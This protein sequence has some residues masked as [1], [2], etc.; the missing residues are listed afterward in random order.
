LEERGKIYW[1]GAFFE[2]LQMEFQQYRNYLKFQSEHQLSKEA[3]RMDV[4]IIKKNKGVRIEKNIG[5]IFREHNVFDYKSESDS[6]S[7][8][9]YN[10]VF[11]YVGLYSSF[12]RVP[13]SEITVSIALTMFPRK[14]VKS[15]E[16][17]RGL[18][19]LDL[20]DGIYR[21]DGE[22]IP[23]QILE[24]KRL[25]P[26]NNMF[27]RNLR[28]N[29]STEDASRTLELG[30]K[31]NLL[32]DKSV[33]MDRLIKANLD[34]FME[35]MNMVSETVKELFLEGAEKH[36]WLNKRDEQIKIQDR[37]ETAKKLLLLGDSVEKV[38][39]VTELPIE[40]VRDLLL[41]AQKETT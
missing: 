26:D 34:A 11:G 9:D 31:Y 23:V 37:K 40:T 19:V 7:L 15:L 16:D 8:W 36:G 24:S 4:L 1:H 13:V 10:K 38:V 21:V 39:G 3:L 41:D 27:L 33:Y 35:A 12:E 14:L 28:S 22:I 17:E 6:F 18:K 32:H 20:G 29:L 25:S 30:S 2:A 5:R